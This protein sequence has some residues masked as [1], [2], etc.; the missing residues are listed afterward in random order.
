MSRSLLVLLVD[1]DEPV[2]RAMGRLI[3]RLGYAV[4]Q[5]RNG[6]EAC[7]LLADNE[8]DII[9]S[10]IR[11]PEMTGV[12]LLREVQEVDEGIPVLLITGEPSIDTAMEA[13]EYGAVGY[14][15]KPVERGDMERMLKRAANLRRLARLRQDALAVSGE[16]DSRSDALLA[17][18]D[19]FNRA[20]DSLWVAM[21]P[22]VDA[23]TGR[24]YGYE[25]LLRSDEPSLPH[26][27]AVIEAAERLGRLVDLGRAIRLRGAEI[28]A[29]RPEQGQLFINI[30]PHD[31][32]DDELLD[33]RSPLSRMAERVVLEITERAELPE[34]D[35]VRARIRHLREL[36]FRIAVDDMGAGYAGLTSFATLQ[37]D[38]VKI[39]MSMVRGV[40]ADPVRRRLIDSMVSLCRDMDIEVVAEGVETFA[41][42]QVL[43]ELK[44]DLLQGFLL[45]RPGPPFPEVSWP[46]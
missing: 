34:Q 33:P 39:D 35:D 11:M 42:L 12:Q 3:T 27:G 46:L 13:V 44:V 26:P 7:A 5:A 9:V 25:A 32:L 43:I 1:D 23:D 8:I 38:I 18:D 30:H 16:H 19:S 21:Q 20:M 41:E 24:V 36:G 10:D 2:R 17:L 29:G 37:P 14:L 6:E 4:V 40:D 31:L 22:L 28:M 15:P 45:A